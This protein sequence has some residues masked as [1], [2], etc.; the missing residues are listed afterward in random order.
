MI[1]AGGSCQ[2]KG[3]G[4]NSATRVRNVSDGHMSIHLIFLF[5]HP[6]SV[7]PGLEKVILCDL[8]YLDLSALYTHVQDEW[9]ALDKE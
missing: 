9:A 5:P 6:T 2:F 7:H 3:V 1:I 8:P 4:Y